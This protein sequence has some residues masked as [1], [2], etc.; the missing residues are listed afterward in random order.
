MK[1]VLLL[2]LVT[3]PC[4]A[5]TLKPV[6]VIKQRTYYLNG[7]V[8]T[9]LVDGKS[10]EL[11]KIDLPAHTKGCYYSFTTAP[12]EDGTQLLNLGLQ[13]TA[14]IYG[15]TPGMA[16]A[17]KIKVPAGADAVDVYVLSAGS[18]KAFMDKEDKKWKS[19]RDISVHNA[20]DAVQYIDNTRYGNSFYIGLRNPSA[21]SGIGIAIEVVA[22]VEEVV[23][24]TP[25]A[26]LYGDL[27]WKAYENQD[28]KKALTYYE[29][30]LSY[31]PNLAYV[32]FNRALIYLLQGKSDVVDRYVEAIALAEKDPDAQKIFQNALVDLKALQVN[33]PT[34]KNI[35]AIVELVSNEIKVP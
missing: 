24:D 6:T 26:E 9:T 22:M 28:Y 35:D 30:A 17:S 31:D 13:L 27:G 12:G 20:K 2:L 15:G 7:G 5:Q 23:I 3:F 18:V 16:I 32:H 33:K 29:K 14:A 34:L 11:I 10:R 21:L 19:H 25:K 8:R 4:L 1:Y